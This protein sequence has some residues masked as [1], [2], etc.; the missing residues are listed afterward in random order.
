MHTS[1][2]DPEERCARLPRGRASFTIH[3]LPPDA[4]LLGLIHEWEAKARE[5]RRRDVAAETRRR[6]SDDE[7]LLFDLEETLTGEK[8]GEADAPGRVLRVARSGGRVQAVAALFRCRRAIF[9]EYLVAAP[10]NLLG[11]D[12]P[13]AIESRRGAGTALLVQ[14]VRTSLAVGR[15]GRVALQAENPRC[16]AVYEHLGFQRMRPADLPRTLV[17][18]REGWWTE[19]AARLAAGVESLAE[20]ESPWLL[21]DPARA[22]RQ[23]A[24]A[25]AADVPALRPAA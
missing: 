13:P 17:P 20:R 12:D 23:G 21:F 18:S 4:A 3:R 11:P 6:L 10:W 2:D 24:L 16:L 1:L 15:G 7:R 22:P 19:P 25:L 8:P 14:A 5:L 9:V